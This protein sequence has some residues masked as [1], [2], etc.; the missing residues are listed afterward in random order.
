[1]T[2]HLEEANLLTKGGVIPWDA[3]RTEWAKNP[4]QASV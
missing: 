2:Y 4:N 3:E 1:M